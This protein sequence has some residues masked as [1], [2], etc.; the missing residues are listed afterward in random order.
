MDW[1]SVITAAIAGA[2]GGGVGGL[3]SGFLVRIFG[4]RVRGLGRILVIIAAIASYIFLTPFI[5]PA[6]GPLVRS[7]FSDNVREEVRSELMEQPFF[8]A[9]IERFPERSEPMLGR[10]EQAY[11]TGGQ[12]QLLTV[13]QQIGQ[14]IGVS[15]ISD[16][17]PYSSDADLR[18]FFDA[19]EAIGRRN[20]N[21][22]NLC[23]TFYYNQIAPQNVDLNDMARFATAPG[24]DDLMN[25]MTRIIYN[26]GDEAIPVDYA[27][28]QAAMEEALADLYEGGDPA[29]SRFLMGAMPRNDIEY[30]AACDLMLLIFERYREHPQNEEIIRMLFGSG[31]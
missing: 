2:I 23:Y 31:G 28:A 26:A 10:A 15:V 3:I 22:P 9:Y 13:A 19:T 12:E 4:D 11:R 29:D 1:A 25:A 5:E 17:G 27:T 6:V 20:R 30:L 14:E 24:F 16:L 18:R 8:A 7:F 21:D